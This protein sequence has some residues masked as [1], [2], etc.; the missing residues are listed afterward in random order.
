MDSPYETTVMAH[1]NFVSLPV[2]AIKGRGAAM[3][4]AHRFERTERGAFD[5]GWGDVSVPMA[6][7]APPPQTQV[8]W[9]NARSAITRNESPDIYFE[10]GLNPYR[11]CEHGCAYCYAR[12]SHSYLDLSPGLDFETRIIAKRNIATVLRA[13][14]GRASYLPQQIALGT[15]TDCYQPIERELG[16]TRAVLQVMHDSHQPFG[17][18]T[19][20]SGIERDLDLIAPMAQRKLS[21][22]YITITTLDA[23]LA[24]ALEP[25]AAAPHRRLRTIRALAAQGVPVGV[26]V[27]PQIPFVNNDMELVLEAAW[28]AGARSAFYTVLRLPWEINAIFQQW[29]ELHCPDRAGRVMARI[30]EMRGGKDYDANFAT[31]MKG[32]GVWAAL[33]KQRFD[34]ACQSLG[35][36]RERVELD[37]SQFRHGLARGQSVLF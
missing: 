12:P 6:N 34:K 32:S 29:L 27:G 21:A 25:R 37:V 7:D 8:I 10:Y 36:N 13:E 1:D 35:F 15:V 5:D 9:E 26:S 20:G 4:I 11:G 30:R 16:L 3:R 2:H 14:L 18:V 22:A 23:G 24:R 28:D 31:R 17:I 33:I 19:K